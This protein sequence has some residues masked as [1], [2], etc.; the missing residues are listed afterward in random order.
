MCVAV[1]PDSNRTRSGSRSAIRTSPTLSVVG[2]HRSLYITSELIKPLRTKYGIQHYVWE[3]YIIAQHATSLRVKQDY[4]T[5]ASLTGPPA[6]TPIHWQRATT[7]HRRET[8][9]EGIVVKYDLLNA[10]RHMRSK[11][12]VQHGQ[13]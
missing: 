7:K 6:L 2:H 10:I 4:L 3:G 8:Q 12:K 11:A 1:V 13:Q 9:R 5:L